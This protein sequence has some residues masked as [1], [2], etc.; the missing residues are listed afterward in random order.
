MKKSEVPPHWTNLVSKSERATDEDYDLAKTWLFP[1]ADS[2]DIAMQTNTKPSIIPTDTKKD[3]A[4]AA[5]S[6]NPTTARRSGY[7]TSNTDFTGSQNVHGISNEDSIQSPFSDSVN[8]IL[9]QMQD[10]NSVPALINLETTG[11]RRSP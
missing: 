8:D 4:S 11:L 7:Q 5:P 6:N 3:A 10:E 2:G 9:P 1:E